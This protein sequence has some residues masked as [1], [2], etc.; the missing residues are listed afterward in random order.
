MT[1]N[2]EPKPALASSTIRGTIATTIATILLAILPSI[3]RII[4]NHVK[5]EQTKRDVQEIVN[6]INTICTILG[7]GGAGTAVAGRLSIGDLYTA[8]GLPGPDKEDFESNSIPE[9]V[10]LKQLP[11]F[12]DQS[13][14]SQPETQ[15]EEL[16]ENE[17][18]ITSSSG[19]TQVQGNPTFTHES[20]ESMTKSTTSDDPATELAEKDLASSKQTTTVKKHGPTYWFSR[21]DST[22]N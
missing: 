12:R 22:V 9:K 16:W 17:K 14:E 15:R 2:L 1:R 11:P 10:E 6:I 18:D 13:L 21:K 7:L 8:R 19:E 20:S 3:Q 4:D 5:N